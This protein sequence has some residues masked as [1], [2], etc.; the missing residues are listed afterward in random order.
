MQKLGQ[1][2]FPPAM[3]AERRGAVP[4]SRT[5]I[6]VGPMSCILAGLVP[7]PT[8]SFG[9]CRLAWAPLGGGVGGCLRLALPGVPQSG[10]LGRARRHINISPPQNWCLGPMGSL[11]GPMAHMWMA[12]EAATVHSYREKQPREPG[13]MRGPRSSVNE[14]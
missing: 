5:H 6:H 9:P 1:L 8:P 7:I 13:P 4:P 2:A 11:E 3:R 12:D 14:G 10:V